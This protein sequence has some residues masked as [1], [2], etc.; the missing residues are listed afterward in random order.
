MPWRLDHTGVVTHLIREAR[1]IKGDLATLWLKAYKSVLHKLVETALIRHQVLEKF[2]D[3]I[4]D[5]YNDFSATITSG[6]VT[7]AWYRLEKGIITG[8]T[9]LV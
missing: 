3:L 2:C 4:M 1:E 6:Q 9:I 8:C 7:S 5:C